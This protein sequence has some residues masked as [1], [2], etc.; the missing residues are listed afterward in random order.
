MFTGSGSGTVEG[1]VIPIDI[2]LAT[3]RP[4]SRRAAAK[5]R[6]SPAP[7]G[8]ATT[9]SRSCSAAPASSAPRRYYAEQAGAEA[10]IIFNQGNTPDR[11]ELI[12]ADGTSVD[13]PIPGA[14]GPVTHGIPVVGASFADGVALSATGS[15]A[16]VKVLP[17]EKRTDHNV[18]AELP[19]KNRTT[20]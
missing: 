20:S 12:V 7:T 11:E 3:G 15:T 6:T 18:I 9:T 13:Q 16:F 8:A 10:V 4:R 1:N 19:G 5:P 17:A 14:P 2:N